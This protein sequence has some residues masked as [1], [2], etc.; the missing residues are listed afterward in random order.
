[1]DE[2]LLV[3]RR[4]HR[5]RMDTVIVADVD[6]GVNE[7]Q[8]ARV[9]ALELDSTGF[10]AYQTPDIPGIPVEWSSLVLAVVGRLIV[11]R[12]EVRE[13]K[14]RARRI[15]SSMQMNSLQTKP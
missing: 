13:Q 11:K 1:M 14:I 12:V 7:K 5:L 10:V 3:Q 9:R 15:R 6:L 4:L 2:A 8:P